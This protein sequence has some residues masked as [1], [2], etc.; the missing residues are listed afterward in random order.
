[1]TRTKGGRDAAIN[2]RLRA[3]MAE[4]S[5]SGIMPVLGLLLLVVILFAAVSLVF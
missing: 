2:Q 5:T 4:D 3:D 1:M